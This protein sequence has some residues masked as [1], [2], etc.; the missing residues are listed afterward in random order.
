[1]VVSE[2]VEGSGHEPSCI[3][4]ATKKICNLQ[5]LVTEAFKCRVKKEDE[6]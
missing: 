4:V 1:M 2:N 3:L 6:V 5:V